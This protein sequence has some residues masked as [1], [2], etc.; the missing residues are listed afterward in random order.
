MA[1]MLIERNNLGIVPTNRKTEINARIIHEEVKL[2]DYEIQD[3]ALFSET[4]YK[5]LKALWADKAI[6]EV[7]RRRNEYHLPDC[8]K[9]FLDDLDRIA[10]ED[11]VPNN[12]DVLFTRV[13]T[14]GVIETK[15]KAKQTMF[16][17][18][19]VGGQRSERRKWIHCFDNVNAVIF[20]CAIS[21]FDQKLKENNETNRLLESLALFRQICNNEYFATGC[22][23]ILFLN[24]KD[25]FAE[26]IKTTSIAVAFSTYKGADT[27][28]AQIG[29][30][31]KKFEKQNEN[32]TKMLFIHHTCATD[33]NHVE[34]VLE[35]VVDT[36]IR[37][38]VSNA[39]MS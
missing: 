36:V 8:T 11:F 26:K 20:I 12:Q 24:K 30:I 21:E 22:S 25:L 7:F 23:M 31:Q 17:V 35:A 1:A 14:S 39:G 5:A 29:F 37:K 34:V 6:Q 33:T 28:A 3:G 4:V 38:N 10:A 18:Y 27:Y 9:Y 2:I 32:P 13:Q 15:F 16:R 19:D